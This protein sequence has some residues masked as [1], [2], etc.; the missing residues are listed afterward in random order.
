L[1]LL[2]VTIENEEDCVRFTPQTLKAFSGDQISWTNNDSQEHAPAALNADG[3]N[4]PLTRNPVGPDDV[5]DTFSPSPL[6]NADGSVVKLY[7]IKYVCANHP[8]SSTEQ[9][10][11]SVTPNP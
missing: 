7:E 1:P 10:V 5:S 2:R 9:G 3:S 6:F 8:N 11:I 4:T